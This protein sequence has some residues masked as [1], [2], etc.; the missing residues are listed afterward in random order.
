M[1]IAA[2]GRGGVLRSAVLIIELVVTGLV[3]TE[4]VEI[5]LVAIAFVSIMSSSTGVERDR[6]LVDVHHRGLV[7]KTV[8]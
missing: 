8:R 7:V 2:I 3:V 5:E 1:A 6:R 4:L